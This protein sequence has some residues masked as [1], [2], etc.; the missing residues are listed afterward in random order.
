MLMT[1]GE[2]CTK[3][4]LQIRPGLPGMGDAVFQCVG[5]C[6]MAWR[7][8]EGRP[9]LPVRVPYEQIAEWEAVHG[10]KNKGQVAGTGLYLMEPPEAPEGARRGCC[11]LA[12][13][14]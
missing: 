12:C 3:I 2:A 14:P 9:R 7:W 11:G 5:S 1:E 4:C 6:C 10:Y 8:E 13:R